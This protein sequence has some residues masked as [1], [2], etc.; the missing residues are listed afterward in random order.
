MLRTSSY[1]APLGS[2]TRSQG[3]LR[4]TSGTAFRALVLMP[5]LIARVPCGLTNLVPSAT[6]GGRPS[7]P[8]PSLAIGTRS[9]GCRQRQL[10]AIS[11]HVVGTPATQ[12]G[13]PQ[14]RP[15]STVFGWNQPEL[16]WRMGVIA[17]KHTLDL[18]GRQRIGVEIA[19]AFGA[20]GAGQELV[21]RLVLDAFGDGAEAQALRHG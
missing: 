9:P 12:P 2:L 18:A 11:P 14:T 6:R 13:K 21:L 3:G 7:P 1:C 20:T 5:P 16:D 4:P 8:L 10:P 17:T 15:D 19:L